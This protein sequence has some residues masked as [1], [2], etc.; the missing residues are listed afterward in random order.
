MRRRG[1]IKFEVNEISGQR[2][3][4]GRRRVW[5]DRAGVHKRREQVPMPAVLP[6]TSFIT[7]SRARKIALFWRSSVGSFFHV[8]ISFYLIS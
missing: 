7:Y 8:Y 6:H 4:I 5:F 1:G 2:I 3:R